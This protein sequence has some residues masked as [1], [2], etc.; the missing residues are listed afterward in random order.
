MTQDE[1]HFLSDSEGHV[2]A[3]VVPI[4]RWREI[5]SELETQHLLKSDAMR[6]RLLAA[7]SRDGGLS[8]DEAVAQFGSEMS[9]P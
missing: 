4:E 8:L 5:A 9:E 6:R 7:R 3:V 1:L 2:T